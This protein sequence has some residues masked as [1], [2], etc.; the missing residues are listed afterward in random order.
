MAVEL[1]P[2][3]RTDLEIRPTPIPMTR[4]LFPILTSVFLALHT[5]LGCCWHHAH[6]C[7]TECSGRSSLESHDAH[8]DPCGDEC[9]TAGGDEHQHHGWHECQGRTCVFL[10]LGGRNAH[11]SAIQLQVP[12]VSCLPCGELPVCVFATESFFATDAL[13]PPLR[14]HLAHHVLLL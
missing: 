9:G 10:D 2:Q 11:G 14:L 1:P 5:V 3:Q 8:A 4:R 13:L 7:T 6:A 12:A